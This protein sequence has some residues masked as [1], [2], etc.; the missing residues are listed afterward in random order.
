MSD[1]SLGKFKQAFKNASTYD[2]E[3]TAGHKR[4][5]DVLRDIVVAINAEGTFSAELTDWA[6]TSP[7]LSIRHKGD[8][9][10]IAFRV[11]FT[12]DVFGGAPNTALTYSA[13]R[14][15]VGKAKGY[16]LDINSDR[17]AFLND[18]GEAVAQCRNESKLANEALQ[19]VKSRKTPGRE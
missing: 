13:A 8:Q 16:S 19:Y 18:L 17:E 10:P 5:L 6:G 11:E 9:L 7:A 1:P 14:T 12:F 4:Q 3:L 2:A 15:P